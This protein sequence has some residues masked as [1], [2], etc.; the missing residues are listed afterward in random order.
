MDK[1][2]TVLSGAFQSLRVISNKRKSRIV[3]GGASA[4]ADR[5]AAAAVLACTDVSDSL[6][7][8]RIG[9]ADAHRVDAWRSE[10]A[11][12]KR[13][14]DAIRARI[15]ALETA[16]DRALPARKRSRA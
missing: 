3:S 7:I 14:Q 6:S 10:I 4:A 15:A 5:L 8:R 9:P 2:R 16:E 12:L 1:V 13:H 11:A